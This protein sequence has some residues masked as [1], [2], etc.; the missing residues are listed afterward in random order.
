MYWSN[1]KGES[2]KVK[3]MKLHVGLKSKESH[4]RMVTQ[5]NIICM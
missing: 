2:G 3:C 1:W 5:V 4:L